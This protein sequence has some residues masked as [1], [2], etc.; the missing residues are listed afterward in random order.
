M[1]EESYSF[2]HLS[3]RL[4]RLSSSSKRKKGDLPFKEMSPNPVTTNEKKIDLRFL[5]LSLKGFRCVM[6]YSSLTKKNMGYTGT[7]KKQV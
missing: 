4:L 6:K 2:Y 3:L 7:E 5:E 1:G